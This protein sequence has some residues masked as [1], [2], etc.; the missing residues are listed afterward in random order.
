MI[1]TYPYLLI[2]L[3]HL[4]C[5][6]IRVIISLF[7]FHGKTLLGRNYAIF[8][9]VKNLTTAGISNTVFEK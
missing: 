1:C 3:S 6:D 8:K 2:F 9:E 4:G 5:S 7:E